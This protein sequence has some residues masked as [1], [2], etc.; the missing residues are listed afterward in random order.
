M[1]CI[2][3]FCKI[4]N[5]IVSA[6]SNEAHFGELIDLARKYQVP[7]EPKL[8]NIEE[9]QYIG[10]EKL[11]RKDNFDK[12]TGRAVYALD[13]QI[14]GMVYVSIFRS[15]KFGGKLKSFSSSEAE[16]VNGLSVQRLSKWYWSRS[17]WQKYMVCSTGKEENSCLGTKLTQKLAALINWFRNIKNCLNS[18]LMK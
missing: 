6:G 14:P 17:F 13:V 11:N 16:K 8:K 12:T 9:F 7:K 1:E 2:R 10:N 15:P 18:Q 5:G 4:D 3:R